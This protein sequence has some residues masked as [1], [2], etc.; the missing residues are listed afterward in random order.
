MVPWSPRW[1]E[2]QRIDDCP[3]WCDGGEGSEPHATH[4]RSA[5]L[6]PV[7]RASEQHATADTP[8]ASE[9]DV[10]RFQGAGD[11]EEWVFVGDDV[12]GWSVT[13]ESAS[14]IYRA[15]GEVLVALGAEAT[16]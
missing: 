16:S 4:S 3:W 11:R 10:V 8:K 5:G 7:I 6:Q 14:R 12:C 9:F 2:E 1:G 13:I 15:L